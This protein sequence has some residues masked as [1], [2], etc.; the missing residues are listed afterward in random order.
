[1]RLMRDFIDISYLNLVGWWN[2]FCLLLLSLLVSV[3]IL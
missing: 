3:S 2:V 1:M